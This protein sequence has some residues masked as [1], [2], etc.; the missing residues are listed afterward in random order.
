MYHLTLRTEYSFKQCFGFMQ[1]L[2]DDYTYNG[3]IGIADYNTLGFYKLYEICKKSG[4]KAIYGLRVTVVEDATVKIKPRGQWGKPYIIIARNYHGLQEIFKLTSIASNKDSGNFYFRGNISSSDIDNLTD[5]VYVIS[6]DPIANRLDF[7]GVDNTTRPSVLA[8][9]YPKLYVENNNYTTNDMRKVYELMAG[10]SAE[11]KTYPQHVLYRDEI[12]HLGDECVSNLQIIVDGC[13]DIEMRK[14]ENIRYKGEESV[15][16][17]CYENAKDKN[18][19]MDDPEYNERFDKEIK[20]IAEK[21]YTDYLLVVA[22]LINEAKKFCLVGGGGRGSSAGSLV[23][24]LLNITEIDPIKHGLIFERFIDINRY[25]PPDVD[26]DFPDNARLKVTR[27]L[28][29]TYGKD[30]VKTMSTISKWK[31]KVTIGEFAKHMEI[32]RFE[33]EAVKDIIIERAGG[34]ARASYCLEDT[35]KGTDVGKEFLEK[36]PNMINVKYAEGHAKQKGKHAAGIIV[37]NDPIVE[38]CGIDERDDTALLD[39]KDAEKLNLLKIDVLGLRTLSVLQDCAKAIKMDYKE[40]YNLPL[41][42]EKAYKVFQSKRLG[43]IFQFEGEAMKSINDSAPMEK[44]ADIVAAG[45]LGRPG[46]LS[47]GGTSRY[48]QLRMGNRVP[49]YYCP[50]HK[51]IT[52]ETYGIVIYQEQMMFLC[53]DIAGMSWE[54]VSSLRKAASKSLGEEFFDKYRIKFVEGAMKLSGYDEEKANKTWLDI[55]SMGSY[56]FNKSHSV[57]YGQISYWTAYMKAHHPI[58]FIASI[59][60]NAKDDDSSLKI[61]REFYESEN[62]VFKSVEPWTSDTKWKIVGD[63]LIGGLTNIKGVGTA[64]ALKLIK[65]RKGKIPFTPAMKKHFDHPKTPFDILY[66]AQHHWGDIYKDPM[67]YGVKFVDYIKNVEAAREYVIIGKMIHVD[68][69][70][71]NDVQSIAKRGGEILDGPHMKVHI[72]LED[73]TG[74]IMCIVNRYIYNRLSAEFLREKL[75][76][77]WYCVTGTVM[78]GAKILF[79]K[80]VANLNRDIGLNESEEQR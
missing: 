40:Y 7:I 37:C 46:A 21:G 36:F 47:S 71:V 53:K 25:D 34:D 30:N 8:Y 78:S 66:P 22:D 16:D 15:I 49:L 51:R 70:D 57:V 63:K 27:Y 62:L 5:D 29:K 12:R 31:P 54:D 28:E 38:Y 4:N 67:K 80:E 9:D 56:A 33:T 14:A 65:M 3:V 79:V 44:F 11:K 43:G 35:L 2:H 68:D 73:D 10:N 52:E 77:T 19:D 24:Y 59:L 72:R 64:T 20:L 69:V 58:E 48:V 55:S 42:D 1:E 45:A 17:L 18:V 32:P 41:D 6:T 50:I 76:E 60:N 13:D 74:V 75:G 23:C 61:L 26:T 39:K